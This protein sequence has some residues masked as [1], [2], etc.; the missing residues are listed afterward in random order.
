MGG[1]RR[2]RCGEK[3]GQQGEEGRATSHCCVASGQGLEASR[4]LLSSTP[5]TA[6]SGKDTQTA[7]APTGVTSKEGVMQAALGA[8]G[9]RGRRSETLRLRGKQA[10]SRQVHGDPPPT[11]RTP[12]TPRGSK[13][14]IHCIWL[15]LPPHP[16]LAQPPPPCH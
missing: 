6:S 15:P 10:S 2:G 9:R 11:Q 13:V 16:S 8:P 3:A 7:Q 5:E 12:T 14:I 1:R 4:G